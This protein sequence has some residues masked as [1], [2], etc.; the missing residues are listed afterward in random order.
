MGRLPGGSASAGELLH[1]R[2]VVLSEP[3]RDQRQP[4]AHDPLRQSANNALVHRAP[5]VQNADLDVRHRLAS[6]VEVKVQG[7][8]LHLLGLRDCGI[9]PSSVHAGFNLGSVNYD[10]HSVAGLIHRL[11]LENWTDVFIAVHRAPHGGQDRKLEVAARI[12]SSISAP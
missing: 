8:E 5:D 4:V 9:R 7:A 1:H 2:A 11:F 3:A 10:E 12:G 6:G